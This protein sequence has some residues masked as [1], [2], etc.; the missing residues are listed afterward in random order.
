M[1]FDSVKGRRRG[2]C[3]TPRLDPSPAVIAP[4]MCTLACL[5]Q[6]KSGAAGFAVRGHL[7]WF[8]G[9]AHCSPARSC[10][11]F[12]AGH[13]TPSCEGYS[14]RGSPHRPL[15]SS[16]DGQPRF[17]STTNLPPA[18][19]G[20]QF[21]FSTAWPHTIDDVTV[22]RLITPNRQVGCSGCVLSAMA[23]LCRPC[24]H[25]PSVTH[26]LTRS[27]RPW[28]PFGPQGNGELRGD[29]F[30]DPVHCQAVAEHGVPHESQLVVTVICTSGVNH[31]RQIDI[32]DQSRFGGDIRLNPPFPVGKPR[33]Y[34]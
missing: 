9:G 31:F 2:G 18:H 3:P 17:P 21:P 24:S 19:H 11:S 7:R 33:R 8:R 30:R 22:S 5:V 25:K 32:K 29:L 26:V 27:Q 15:P 23:L 10:L 13:G 1:I 20:H 28:R 12:V 6:A 34:R 16:F 14:T 4:E